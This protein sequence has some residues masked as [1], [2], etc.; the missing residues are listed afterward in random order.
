MVVRLRTKQYVD[1]NYIFIHHIWYG[2]KLKFIAPAAS[3]VDLQG[4]DLFDF[5][6]SG[7]LD[8]L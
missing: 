7:L 4:R 8:S 3:Q 5:P 2:I 6:E 1:I